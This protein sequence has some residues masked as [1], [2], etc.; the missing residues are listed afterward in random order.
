MPVK[1]GL[2]AKGVSRLFPFHVAFDKEC[3]IVQAG[4]VRLNPDIFLF[5]LFLH[6]LIT[7]IFFD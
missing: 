5:L 2:S 4:A 1:Y 3:N 6:Y 7:L